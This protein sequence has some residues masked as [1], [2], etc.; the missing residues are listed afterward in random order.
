MLISGGVSVD[1]IGI[2]IFAWLQWRQIGVLLL[3]S[4]GSEWSITN[5]FLSLVM[6]LWGIHVRSGFWSML[7]SFLQSTLTHSVILYSNDCSFVISLNQPIKYY[8]KRKLSKTALS[9]ACDTRVT[10]FEKQSNQREKQTYIKSKRLILL[11]NWS[12]TFLPEQLL[13]SVQ[14]ASGKWKYMNSVFSDTSKSGNYCLL[15]F[16]LA[17]SLHIISFN[18]Y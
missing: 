6:H 17:P 2:L 10:L 9:D 8:S 12:H 5:L 1:L 18:F 3:T 14:H 15:I 13:L 4:A 11:D 16:F 7:P